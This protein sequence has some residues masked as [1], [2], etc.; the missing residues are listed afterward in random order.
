MTPIEQIEQMTAELA[1]VGAEKAAL[2]EQL[3]A[4]TANA[5]AQDGFAA[6]IEKLTAENKTL[7]DQLVAAIA[8]RDAANAEV[9]KAKDAMALKPAAFEH[10][11]DG[12]KPV[13]DGASASEKPLLEKLAELQAMDARAAREFYKAHKQ[14]ILRLTK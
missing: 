10:I 2:V 9:A 8:E 11:S 6:S 14:E 5:S 7:A 3:Q 12:T 1:A 13:A 4:A